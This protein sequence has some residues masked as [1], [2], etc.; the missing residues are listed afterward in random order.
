ME[1]EMLT[2]HT[3]TLDPRPSLDADPDDFVVDSGDEGAI[4]GIVIA[5]TTDNNRLDTDGS[6]DFVAA[7]GVE[8]DVGQLSRV[9]VIVD[10][11]FFGGAPSSAHSGISTAQL[12]ISGT[13][14]DASAAD[15]SVDGRYS[16]VFDGNADTS[17]GHT[18]GINAA[19]GDASVRSVT[20]SD[21]DTSGDTSGRQFD[22]FVIT[23]DRPVDPSAPVG[24]GSVLTVGGGTVD[25]RGA[26]IGL[27]VGGAL[28]TGARNAAE[29]ADAF[30]GA[31]AGETTMSGV[32][33]G[34]IYTITIKALDAGT[35][36]LDLAAMGGMASPTP[37]RNRR[38]Y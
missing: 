15:G 5:A 17:G 21:A 9:G 12:T 38:W 7:S 33:T 30:M 11:D 18:G 6:D 25:A 37:A 1:G 19:F 23:F 8:A 32:G 14:S 10:D 27:I 34:R 4:A 24:D 28:G 26:A 3:F 13:I 36:D 2:A 29:D 16:F 31:D 20:Y 35:D 22:G